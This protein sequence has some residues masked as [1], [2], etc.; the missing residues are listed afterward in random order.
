MTIS[1][2][3]L[4]TLR[5]LHKMTIDDLVKKSGVSKTTIRQI[6]KGEANPQ[7]ETLVLLAD[8]LDVPMDVLCN[9][10]INMYR[11]GDKGDSILIE[12]TSA[13]NNSKL[14]GVIEYLQLMNRFDR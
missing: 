9:R 4:K 1:G 12:Y 11:I 7:Y 10:N 13:G 8:A 2:M 6:E 5:N 14:A 3:P